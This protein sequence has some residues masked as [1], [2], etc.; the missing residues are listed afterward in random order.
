[1]IKGE[2]QPLQM[3]WVDTRLPLCECIRNEGAQNHI[4][5]VKV[6][7]SDQNEVA[8][9]TRDGKTVVLPRSVLYETREDALA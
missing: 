1:M 3:I 6:L 2:L 4:L 5:P 7:Q 8:I 9:I